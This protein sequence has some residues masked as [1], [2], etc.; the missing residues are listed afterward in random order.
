MP[1]FLVAR[2]LFALFVLLLA[3]PQTSRA[4]GVLGHRAVARIAENHLTAN[5]KHR[6]NLLLG[7]ETMPLVSTWA[8]E[9][10]NDLM[11]GRIRNDVATLLRSELQEEVRDATCDIDKDQ[12]AD[13][14]VCLGETSTERTQQAE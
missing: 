5:A 10:R 7:T 9:L 3:L 13:L 11:R 14:V 1:R 4:W 8:D 6:I 12:P 2:S